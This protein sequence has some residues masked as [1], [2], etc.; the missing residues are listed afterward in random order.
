MGAWVERE[1]RA[2]RGHEVTLRTVHHVVSMGGWKEPI[3]AETAQRNILAPTHVRRRE[4]VTVWRDPPHTQ[5]RS[6]LVDPR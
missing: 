3:A 5:P 4:V 2:V 6:R 1:V